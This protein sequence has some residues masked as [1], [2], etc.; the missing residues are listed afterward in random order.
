MSIFAY[1]FLSTVK[2]E[3]LY[4]LCFLITVPVFSQLYP[5]TKKV[6]LAV[7]KHGASFTDNYTWLEEMRS[8]ETMNWVNAQNTAIDNHLNQIKTSGS[9]AF[10]IKEYDH[11]SRNALP[12]KKGKYYYS[13]YIRDAKTAP[14][15]YFRENLNDE[16]TE[17]ATPSQFYKDNNAVLMGYY[18]SVNSALLAYKISP[19]G[20]DRHEVRF[21][22][23][24]KVTDLKDILRNI[25]FSDIEWNADKGVFYKQNSNARTFEKDSTYQLYYHKIGT[26]QKED[27]LVFDSSSRESNFHFITTKA[28]LYIIETNKAE[29]KRT[30]YYTRLND[31]KF[32]LEKLSVRRGL[33]L[34]G[35]HGDQLYF[36]SQDFEWGELRS[37]DV[38]NNT[39]D[40]TVIP[41]LYS[42]LLVNSYFFD[43]YIVCKYKT[44]TKNYLSVYDYQGNFVRKFEAPMGMDFK[45]AFFDTD[46]KNLYVTF[47]S[48]VISYLNYKL[49]IE[50]G[51]YGPFYNEEILP[52]PSLF[53]LDYFETKVTTYKNR[54]GI[55]IP[56]TV[57]HKKG[58]PLNGNNPTLLSAYGGF[59]MISTPSYDTGLLYFLEKGGV[60]AYAEIRGGGERGL[61]WHKEGRGLKKSNTFNDFIDAAEYLIAN[62]YTSSNKLAITGGSQGGL[63]VGVAMTQRPDLFK[64]AIPNVGV[65]DMHN[66]TKY[67]VGK[68][69]LDEYGDPDILNEYTAMMTFS[70]Y[71]NIKEEVNY[72]TTLI[73]T[74]ENDD[75][76]PPFHSYKFA[77]LLQNRK[78]QKNP[79]YLKTLK[80][81]GHYGKVSKYKENVKEDADLYS[82][83][84]YH[85]N[86]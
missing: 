10:K 11:H 83:L 2:K 7:S 61:N 6:P 79:I 31:E 82:F 77:A 65:F 44:Q 30:Y 49:N 19:D 72:P 26:E 68:Y 80:D 81:S 62:K 12:N 43:K 47:F 86:Q 4:L 42:H 39:E 36:S 58:T 74:S 56:I 34:V 60:Y 3:I 46:E 73:I 38:K 14:S 16:P 64:V 24:R 53:P 76:V 54:D 35:A 50:T 23:I 57:I 52:K 78:G 55:D 40:K 27:Q 20:G 37:I 66:F 45:V 48:R 63:L 32:T 51:K 85:L 17:I 59:G 1:Q 75:R 29:T 71:H 15:L 18:P 13:L 5:P 33:N 22:D 9:I 25:K 28:Y 21:S 69:H 70:P 8:A 41:Q 84:L 67:T